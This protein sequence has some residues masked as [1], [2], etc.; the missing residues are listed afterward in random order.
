MQSEFL[1]IKLVVIIV[2][3]K[4]IIK[5]NKILKFLNRC[6]KILKFTY[7][8]TEKIYVNRRVHVQML[9]ADGKSI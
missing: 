8:D 9:R 3:F 2:A 5:S 1:L 6:I 7:F 4:Q